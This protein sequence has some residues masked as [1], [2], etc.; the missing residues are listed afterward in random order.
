MSPRPPGPQP[1]P[2]PRVR[3]RL[4]PRARALRRRRRLIVTLEADTTSDLD[5]VGEML[6]AAREGADVVLAS[7]HGGGDARERRPH[8][9]VLL[10]APPPTR[11]AAAPGLDARTVSSFFRVY[12]AERP[13][14]RLR[15][16][17][18]PVHPRGRLRL[19][20]GDPGQARPRW[21]PGAEVPVTL[22]W[23]RREGESKMRVLP[24]MG[25]YARMMARQVADRGERRRM[26]A[27]RPGVG[28]RRRRPARPRPSRYR[29]AGAG[30]PVTRLRARPRS[31]AG[32][33][34]RTDWAAYHVDRYYHAVLPTDDRVLDAGRGARAGGRD[35]RLRRA[36]RGLLPRRPAGVDVDA[37]RSC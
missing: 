19:Q 3:P 37:A 35:F 34:A 14:R 16:A 11:S 21:A 8:R 27:C 30:V 13:A 15:P 26:S 31:S 23:S 20:G 18:R 5:A 33:R 25:G 36:R 12:R 7:H 6:A 10:A 32:W 28:H 2:G 4:P 22:D 24:T 9:R 29:L 17:R 1:G